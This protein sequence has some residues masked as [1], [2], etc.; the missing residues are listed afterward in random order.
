[1]NALAYSLLAVLIVSSASL[2]GISTLFFT[3]QLIKR[4][5]SVLIALAAGS[6]LGAAFFDLFPEA[7]KL[8]DP[9]QASSYVLAGI[10]VFF[11]I[12]KMLFWYHCH[13]GDCEGH[14]LTYMNLLGD[15]LHN[16]IDGVIIATSFIVDFSLGVVSTLA[17][18]LHELP[19]EIGD[20]FILIYGGLSTKKALFYNFLSALTSFLGVLIA[21]FLYS[22]TNAFISFLI[23][24]AAGGFIYIAAADLIP[25]IHREMDLRKAFFQL[26]LFLVGIFMIKKITM[27]F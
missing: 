1:M 19:Q 10:V 15:G 17:I 8:T 13:N 25:E 9:I 6:L 22:K 3:R 16:M 5:S 12:E 4:I 27:M 24:F 26:V 14:T 7:L 18:L 20:F 11:I 23:P 2:I 21:F